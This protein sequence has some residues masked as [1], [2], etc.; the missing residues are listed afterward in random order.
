[1]ITTKMIIIEN[2]LG[3]FA[4]TYD[5][6]NDLVYQQFEKNNQIYFSSDPNEGGNLSDDWEIV[7]MPRL[8]K[9]YIPMVNQ[10][11]KKLDN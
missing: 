2:E 11:I 3:K 7:D 8:D 6:K 4:F 10:A 5:N 9:D 1:M